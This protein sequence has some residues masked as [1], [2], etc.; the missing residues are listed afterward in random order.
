MANENSFS[1][2]KEAIEEIFIKPIRSV[3]VVD[4]QFPTLDKLVSGEKDD[5]WETGNLEKIIKICRASK[6]NWILDV[7]DAEN[8]KFEDEKKPIQRLHQS[9]LLVL[10]YHLDGDSVEPY[11]ALNIIENINQNDHFNLVVVYSKE[12]ENKIFEQIMMEFL[13]PWPNLEKK[14]LPQKIQDEMNDEIDELKNKISFIQYLNLRNEHVLNVKNKKAA[15]LAN[16]FIKFFDE[17]FKNCDWDKNDAFQ[18]VLKEIEE[19]NLKSKKMPNL[20]W[21]LP[22]E[23]KSGWL[24]TDRLFLT[25]VK[26]GNDSNGEIIKKLTDAL[27]DWNPSPNR[28]IVTKL[29]NEIEERGVSAE[30][31]ALS[32]DN[33]QRF[34]LDSLLT[35]KFEGERRLQILK[36]I[37]RNSENLVGQVRE[38]VFCFS[39]KLMVLIKDKNAKDFFDVKNYDENKGF[40]RHNAHVCSMRPQGY[41]IQTGHILEIENEYWVCLTPACDLV[42]GQS[43]EINGVVP[44]QA[45]RLFPNEN[46]KLGGAQSGMLVFFIGD[47]K[48]VSTFYSRKGGEKN[49]N[50]RWERMFALDRGCYDKKSC[51]IKIGQVCFPEKGEIPTI[52][53]KTAKIVSQ[54]RY[55]YALNLMNH[56]GQSAT[57]V[58]LDFREQ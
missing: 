42:P 28:L 25:V 33:L 22:N 39:E 43:N 53:R 20:K 10:D 18:W 31:I 50:I 26:K 51:E 23:K 47:D 19:K 4:D 14:D 3:L 11:R 21:S 27:C 38:D 40:L 15:N 2:Y 44:F 46:N 5:N 7:H 45:M 9:D 24:R 13:E 30:N 32:D 29:R 8:I 54:L 35:A 6:R 16:D 57:R 17:N 12:N 48:K 37:E 56:L 34:W 58:G 1:C 55:E 41:H 36:L 52:S 49:A